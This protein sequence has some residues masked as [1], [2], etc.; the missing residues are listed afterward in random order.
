MDADQVKQIIEI[1]LQIVGAA[2]LAAAITPNPADNAILAIIKVAL[3]AVAANWGAAENKIQPMDV[4]KK[5]RGG[6]PNK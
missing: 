1:A 2:S 3:N 4:V 6:P 5:R